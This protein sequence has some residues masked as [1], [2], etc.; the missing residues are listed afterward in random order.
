MS[1]YSRMTY[2]ELLLWGTNILHSNKEHTNAYWEAVHLLSFVLDIPHTRLITL[3]EQAASD[4]EKSQFEN[5]IQRRLQHE[6]LPAFN[7]GL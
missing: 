4:P 3:S 7:A 2:R 5:L 1:N 6:P